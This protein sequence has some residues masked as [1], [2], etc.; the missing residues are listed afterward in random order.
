M[1]STYR[2]WVIAENRMEYTVCVSPW[3]VGDGDRF[4]WKHDEVKLMLRTGLNDVDNKPSYYKD[5]VDFE[6]ALYVIEWDKED[7]GFYLADIKDL[8]DPDSEYHYK[9]RCIREGKI[10]GN[11]YENANLIKSL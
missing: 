5:I 7:T 10:V 6:G 4:S 3:H 9:G 1:E 11:V 2:A 8:G